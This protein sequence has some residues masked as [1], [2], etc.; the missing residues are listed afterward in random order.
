MYLRLGIIFLF[1]FAAFSSKAQQDS[2]VLKSVTIYGL[3]EEKLLTGSTVHTIDSS[4]ITQ[5]GARHLGD[6]LA[7]QL[8]IYFRNYGSGM[9]SGIS[10]R[11]TAPHHTAVLWNG[12]NI[13]SFSLGQADFSI[14]PTTAFEEIKLHT[15]GGSARFGSGA[16]GGTVLLNSVTTSTD[17]PLSIIQDV[18]SFGKFFT[19]ARGS[20]H[21]GKWYASTKVY[22]LQS[23]NDFTIISLNEKQ[24]HA[25]FR[26]TG[27]LQDL[28]YQLSSSKSFSLH[29]WFNDADREVQ[30]PIGQH[31]ATDD[32]QDRNH[33]LNVQFRSNGSYGL[34]SANAGFIS[35]QIEFSGSKSVV[36]R[37]IANARHEYSFRKLFNVQVGAEW[38]H[39]LGEI[40]QYENGEAK[41]DRV[42][43]TA[44][45]Q[46]TIKDRLSLSLNFRQPFVTGF[47]APFLPYLGADYLLVK[48]ERH[49]YRVKGN[50]SKNYRVPTL[51]DRYWQEAGST[52]L[53]PEVSYAAE[54]GWQWIFGKIRMDNNW[55]IQN[56]DQWLQ[57]IPQENGQYVPRNIKAVATKGFDV[58]VSGDL[59]F[60]KLLVTPS[61]SYQFVKSVTTEA[62]PDEQYTIGKQLIYTPKSTASGMIVLKWRTYH[63][64]VNAQYAGKR[65]TDFS[66][67]EMY[68]LPPY[69][70]FNASVGK[71]WNIHRHRFDVNFSVYNILNE[72]YQQYSGR[73]MP[74]RNYNLKI[75]YQLHKKIENEN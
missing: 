29:Y 66:N 12:M 64:S 75:I 39:I 37:W 31:N 67:S 17:V 7:M 52:S 45:L 65:Y 60:S 5:E 69:V 30:P 72:D 26:Q 61:I 74:G 21:V 56:I 1:T 32:Q 18:G 35:D 50:I 16:F 70:L 33:R 23:E 34:F 59:L 38:N 55:F 19:A 42:D 53:L 58:K 3:S 47:S 71:S 51:N 27:F 36:K 6:V 14:L 62:P 40:P 22:N 68:S 43:L 11:G 73:A 4:S 41:E 48:S 2:I 25:A 28:V 63:G 10:L 46:K 9:I 24:D 8:P 44:S 49:T 57:W 13:N 20:F 54:A 15:G